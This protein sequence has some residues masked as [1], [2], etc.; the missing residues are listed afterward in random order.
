VLIAGQGSVQV[1]NSGQFVPNALL[2]P[3]ALIRHWESRSL[4]G[5]VGIENCIYFHKS[6]VVKGVAPLPFFQLVS[7][8]VKS[9]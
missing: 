4:L 1:R 8:G 9:G 6:W 3:T 5:A 7:N 2:V